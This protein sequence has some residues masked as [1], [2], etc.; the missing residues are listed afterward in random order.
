MASKYLKS[1]NQQQYADL[2]N[3]LWSIQNKTCFICCE[4]IDLDIHTTNVDHITALANNGKDDEENFALTHETCNKSKQ[5]SDL[6]IARILHRL[7]K[8][9]EEIS[10]KEGKSASLKHVLTA[11]GGSKYNFKYKIEANGIV[12]SF[13]EIGDN[14]IYESPIYIDNLSKIKTAFVELP[15]EYIYHDELINPRGINSSISKLVKEFSKGN[16]QL[17]LSL[18]RTEDNKVKIFDGQHKAVA[19]ILLNTKKLVIRIFIN[20]DVDI[21][22]ET[23]TNAG[24]VLSQI[25]FDKS[26]MRQLNN[27]L[28]YEKVKQYQED[29]NLK[30]DDFSF[31]E[32]KLVDYFKGDNANRILSA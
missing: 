22:T 24:S 27:T 30:V 8:I 3:K 5:D 21:L 23:N 2:T 15:I 19:Q 16:P 11:Y 6:K 7:K 32:Q 12:Y 20:P 18:G 4:K 25:A 17:H 29:H 1:L 26:V 31:S 14:T 9:Q 13:S 28:Y 10:N